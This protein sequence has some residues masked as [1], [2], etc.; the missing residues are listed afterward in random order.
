MLS[1]YCTYQSASGFWLD[2][3]QVTLTNIFNT[4]LTLFFVEFLEKR[5]ASPGLCGCIAGLLSWWRLSLLFL[6]LDL[7]LIIFWL[8]TE[9]LLL[10]D[11]FFSQ[12]LHRIKEFIL[13]NL[14]VLVGLTQGASSLR[15]VP[16]TDAY[17]IMA[18]ALLSSVL[19]FCFFPWYSEKVGWLYLLLL[20]DPF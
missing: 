12:S 14:I 6:L 1:V 4:L 15:T 11:C 17:A 5:A 7:R 10:L 16:N 19:S 9:V 20:P 8:C 3:L 2:L 18:F 13:T